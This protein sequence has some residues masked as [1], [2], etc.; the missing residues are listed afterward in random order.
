MVD[1]VT[2]HITENFQGTFSIIGKGGSLD[3]Q[4]ILSGRF[5][6]TAFGNLGGTALTLTVSKPGSPDLTF[7][8]SNVIPMTQP[9]VGMSLAFTDVTPGLS[10][11]NGTIDSF[12]SNVAGNFSGSQVVPPT[13]PLIY[14]LPTA[15]NP[16]DVAVYDFQTG[17]LSDVLRF[18]DT[19]SITTNTVQGWVLVYSDFTTA[20]PAD[21]P[22]DTFNGD[23]LAGLPPDFNQFSGFNGTAYEFGVEGFDLAEYAANQTAGQGP[24]QAFYSF[25]SDGNLIP[26]TGG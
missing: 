22:A 14:K 7:N 12:M 8:P 25:L 20:N 17:R 15:V 10:V 2:G 19:V 26:S 9:P 1:P 16:G 13:P 3:G 11:V 21:S 24:E 5:S 4:T 18:T 6:D 23:T